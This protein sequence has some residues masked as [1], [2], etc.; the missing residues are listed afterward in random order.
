VAE[1]HEVLANGNLNV[2]LAVRDRRPKADDIDPEDD[3]P[4]EYS[5]F[6]MPGMD[7]DEEDDGYREVAF[8]EL[9]E[10]KLLRPAA[11]VNDDVADEN[12][13]KDKDQE[14]VREGSMSVN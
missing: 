7:D 10:P 2:R 3:E 6:E 12:D 8:A 1:V 9:S 4:R 5:G 11:G 14:K 13:K